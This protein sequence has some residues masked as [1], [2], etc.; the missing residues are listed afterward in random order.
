MHRTPEWADNAECTLKFRI[1][2]LVFLAFIVSTLAAFPDWLAGHLTLNSILS[3][4][5]LTSGDDVGQGQTE[6]R[7]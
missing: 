4:L 7:I 6:N 1:F 2:L 5:D 3:E